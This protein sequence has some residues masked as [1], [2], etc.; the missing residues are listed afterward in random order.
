MK[1][2]PKGKAGRHTQEPGP[3]HFPRQPAAV[4]SAE[5]IQLLCSHAQSHRNKHLL[6]CCPHGQTLQT[7]E[8]RGW[9]QEQQCKHESRAA[10]S[11]TV[12]QGEHQRA[13]S[14]P[15]RAA[16]CCVHG[17][18]HTACINTETKRH[19]Q[20][21]AA[22]NKTQRRSQTSCIPVPLSAVITLHFLPQQLM[23]TI[24]FQRCIPVSPSDTDALPG[25][26]QLFG[27][28]KAGD[29]NSR[30]LQRSHVPTDKKEKKRFDR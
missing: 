23:Y 22:D 2:F 26:S 28:C 14:A 16:P 29:G 7:Q 9:G 8:T 12:A 10:P 18:L 1:T 13:G 25:S 11:C 15:G 27:I 20:G 21:H 6:C 19:A 3:S 5:N 4:E 30:H 17:H 24:K